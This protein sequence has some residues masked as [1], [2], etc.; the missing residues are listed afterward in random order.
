MKRKEITEKFMMIS[1]K[2]IVS[3]FN[4]LAAKLFLSRWRDPQLQVGENSSEWKLFR[5]DKIEVKNF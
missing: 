1:K 3:W 5:L 2:K 4:L